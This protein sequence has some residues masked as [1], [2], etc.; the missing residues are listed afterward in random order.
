M[1]LTEDE[2]E[3]AK[4]ALID[5]TSDY[6]LSR[7]CEVM[8]EKLVEPIGDNKIELDH[9]QVDEV[10]CA[11]FKGLYYERD[12]FDLDDVSLGIKDGE[13]YFTFNDKKDEHEK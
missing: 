8:C 7:V 1:K 2:M 13:I 5:E 12:E 9:N 11:V 3:S 4:C 10:V 6:I